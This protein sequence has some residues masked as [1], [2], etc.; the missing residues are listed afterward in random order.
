MDNFT[1]L[2][3]EKDSNDIIW[4]GLDVQDKPVNILT[5]DVLH[6]IQAA[7]QYCSQHDAKGLVIHSLKT[8]GFIAGADIEH[9][10]GNPTATNP[11][12]F[13]L[14]YI[15]LGQKT[16]DTVEQLNIPTVALIDGFCMGGGTELSLACDYMICS[17]HPSTKI[18]LPEIKLGIH[19]G[20]GGTVRSIRKMGV[21]NAM[22]MMLTGR[23]YKARLALKNRTG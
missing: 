3:I 15:Q 17:D 7:C 5:L 20:F 12:E 16:C 18:S 11:L 1:H 4:L 21:L 13:A 9:F 22:P 8:N 6:E 19:P 14:E 10:K 2:I 23:H